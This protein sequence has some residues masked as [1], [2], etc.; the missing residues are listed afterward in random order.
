[1]KVH[2]ASALVVR[3]ILPEESELTS[4]GTTGASIAASSNIRI[5][6]K[7][8]ARYLFDTDLIMFLVYIIFMHI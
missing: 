7:A 8:R 4:V 2:F 3:S 1:M 6:K 5:G